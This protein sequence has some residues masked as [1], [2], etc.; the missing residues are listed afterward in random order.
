MPTYQYLC[1]DCGHS[2]EHF[3]RFSEDALTDCPTCDGSVQRV[4]QN[5]GVVFKGS[6]WYVTDSR[7][8]GKKS[9]DGA[10]K[11]ESGEATKS[12]PAEPKKSEPG[13]T[14]KSGTA[15][16]APVAAAS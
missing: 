8:S 6:G 11:S 3:Q 9:E 14:K 1:R 5:V 7:P 12:E 13:D 16:K 4:I 2:F 10:A 15:S